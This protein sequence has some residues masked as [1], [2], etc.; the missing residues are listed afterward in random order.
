MTVKSFNKA[1]G[2]LNGFHLRDD[3]E[4][5]IMGLSQ[6]IALPLTMLFGDT[7]KIGAYWS[8]LW[9]VFG[10]MYFIWDIIHISLDPS[11]P[12][13]KARNAETEFEAA[14]NKKAVEA[15][16]VFPTDRFTAVKL[17]HIKR[18]A[19]AL[20]V[21]A[22]FLINGLA[23]MGMDTVAG[24]SSI[25]FVVIFFA[26][27]NIFYYAAFLYKR[28]L[29]SSPLRRFCDTFIMTASCIGVF[30]GSYSQSSGAS[31]GTAMLIS[32]AIILTTSLICYRKCLKDAENTARNGE[33]TGGI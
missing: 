29:K 17:F 9:T 20:T 22:G 21:S 8:V 15:A 3:P 11:Y 32:A 25:I 31:V 28:G 18:L 6:F 14:G 5:V 4:I 12:V 2:Y 24:G 27:S 10:A 7:S 13:S 23:F 33:P 16:A 1:F 19:I 26:L 30:H